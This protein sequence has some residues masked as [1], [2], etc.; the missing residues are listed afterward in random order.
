M[1]DFIGE[2]KVLKMMDFT[3]DCGEISV[4][5]EGKLMFGS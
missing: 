2:L 5:F 3:G 4:N 1:L